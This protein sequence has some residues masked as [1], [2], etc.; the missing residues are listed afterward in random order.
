MQICD[1]V[2]KQRI[3]RENCKYALDESFHG[4][5]CPR[6]KAAK[7][8][9]PG[10]TT[11]AVHQVTSARDKPAPRSQGGVEAPPSGQE[12]EEPNEVDGVVVDGDRD[13]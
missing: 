13:I 1:Y 7:F 2:Q 9:H 3:C 10:I 5:F 8:C 4:H 12:C 6:R 11:R